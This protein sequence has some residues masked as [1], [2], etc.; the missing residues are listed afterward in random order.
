MLEQ[1]LRD[2]IETLVR[3]VDPHAAFELGRGSGGGVERR[4]REFVEAD[5]TLPR[6][7]VVEERNGELRVVVEQCE[8]SDLLIRS[9]P[10]AITTEIRRIGPER[11]MISVQPV[12]ASPLRYRCAGIT[13]QSGPYEES[14]RSSTL[15]FQRHSNRDRHCPDAGDVQ[16]DRY[17]NVSMNCWPVFDEQRRQFCRTIPDERQD[18]LA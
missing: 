3:A 5:R 7:D 8:S 15:I 2:R 6:L 18:E 16:A 4:L 1:N 11:D 14:N 9:R 12:A 10:A 13:G 17:P